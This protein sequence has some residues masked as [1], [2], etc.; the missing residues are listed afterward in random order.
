LSETGDVGAGLGELKRALQ[1]DPDNL[2]VHIA[3][4]SAYSQAGQMVDARREQAW[5]L[6]ATNDGRNR[7]ALP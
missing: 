7:L 2:E 3:L 6:E 1:L 5:C 4:V